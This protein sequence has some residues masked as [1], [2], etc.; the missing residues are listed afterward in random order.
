MPSAGSRLNPP[1]G[2]DHT[3]PSGLLVCHLV[4]PLVEG[5]SI[6]T[7]H[8]GPTHLSMSRRRCIKGLPELGIENSLTL[9]RSPASLLPGGHPR[10][11]ALQHVFRVTD[12]RDDGSRLER[13]QSFDRGPEFHAIVRRLGL[14]AVH[15]RFGLRVGVDQDGGISTGAGIA[16]AGS[17]EGNGDVALRT[18]RLGVVLQRACLMVLLATLGGPGICKCRA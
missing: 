10:G 9:G 17:I 7:S 18:E 4:H 5:V 16:L 8:P 14:A 1:G 13:V 6:M 11:H 15:D 3:G 12:H 2:A